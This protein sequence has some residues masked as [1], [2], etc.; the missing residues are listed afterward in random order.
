VLL[1]EEGVLTEPGLL[2]ERLVGV[3]VRLRLISAFPLSVTL[4]LLYE[5]LVLNLGLL[6]EGVYDLF[7]LL[8]S[9]RASTALLL[10]VDSR[11]A[12]FLN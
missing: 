1:P 11:V 5:G 12:W 9:D 4:L 10:V 7:E 2:Y 8:Y 6:Y 3:S